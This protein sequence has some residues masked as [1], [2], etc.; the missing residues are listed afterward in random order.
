MAGISSRSDD[1]Y[2]VNDW[3]PDYEERGYTFDEACTIAQ[4]CD[5]RVKAER[6]QGAGLKFPATDTN[7]ILEQECAQFD[8][9]RAKG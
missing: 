8:E 3:L 4:R 1:G 7:V 9:E 2:L 6:A 5:D